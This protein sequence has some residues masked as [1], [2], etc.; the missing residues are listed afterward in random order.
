MTG[1]ERIGGKNVL[2]LSTQVLMV[3][4]YVVSRGRIDT[5]N[6][7]EVFTQKQSYLRK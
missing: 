5:R 6:A 7:Y 4:V 3:E 2:S 1:K